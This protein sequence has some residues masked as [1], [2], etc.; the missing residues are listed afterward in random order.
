M[1]KKLLSIFLTLLLS[2]SVVYADENVDDD[3]AGFLTENEGDDSFSQDP[4]NTPKQIREKPKKVTLGGDLAF[5][6]A[7]GVKKHMVDG[8]QYGGFNQ[9]QIALYLQV[10]AKIND[11]FKL[12][13]S[14][15]MFYD[16]NYKLHP[17]TDYKNELLDAYEMQIRF[18]EVYFQGTLSDEVDLKLGRQIVIWGK[19]DSIRITDVINPLDNRQPG[20]TDIE[21]LRLPTSMLKID[22]Y[23]D[24]WELSAMLIAESRV[25]I[26]APAR[27]E[28]FNVDALVA[29]APNP[30]IDL[31]E[32]KSSLDNLQYAFAMNGVFSGW[33]LSFYGSKVYDQ[34][35][36]LQNN[37]RKISTIK[38]AGSALNIAYGSWLLK[39]ELAY[40]KGV[41]YNTTLDP[42]DRLDL[43]FGFD[44]MGYSNT[45]LSVEL[46]NR[47]IYDYEKQ[48]NAGMDFLQKD[49]MQTAFRYTRN[50]LNDT[51]DF[52]A[53]LS[54][55][56]NSGQN[57]G[58][59][60]V[61]F[62]YDLVDALNAQ[63]GYVEYI[64]G[65]KAVME[66]NKDNDRLFAQVKYSF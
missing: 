53:L 44:Y 21:D 25:M 13:V 28:F 45:T 47:H 57:G 17:N 43:L 48:M 56:A 18:D 6:S 24:E 64:G 58:F 55:F 20:L 8:V 39:S 66:V 15:D 50:F 59:A 31:E 5:K 63:F 30:F 40:L 38:M 41:R 37:K 1:Y 49:E 54:M 33:D 14:G 27:S 46:A 4:Q 22:Y 36:H 2:T 32:P 35:W 9:A 26:E 34:K 3:L 29:S 65:D 16:A 62:E 51:L 10:D 60:R 7:Y 12:R 11:R 61:W 42:K 52:S 19:S 23:V